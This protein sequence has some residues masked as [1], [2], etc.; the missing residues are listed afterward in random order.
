MGRDFE[1]MGT[2]RTAR[3]R[4][5]HKPFR[6]I[7]P[8]RQGNFIGR[9]GSRRQF[10][11]VQVQT[12]IHLARFRGIKHVL[13]L[14]R[15]LT[16]LRVFHRFRFFPPFHQPRGN[17]LVFLVWKRIRIAGL[18]ARPFLPS[19]RLRLGG[20]GHSGGVGRQGR[21]AGREFFRLVEG[22][23]LKGSGKRAGQRRHKLR[24]QLVRIGRGAGSANGLNRDDHFVGVG[25]PV[26]AVGLQ[27]LLHHVVPR[28]IDSRLD[29]RRRRKRPPRARSRQHFINHHAHC[30]QVGPVVRLRRI[31]GLF[32]GHVLGRPQGSAGIGELFAPRAIPRHRRDPKIH[33]LHPAV[34]VDQH[35]GG[36][37]VAVHDA[38]LVGILQGV[39][40]L[41][42]QKPR[43][44]RIQL[45]GLDE[46]V[47]RGGF[48]RL[49]PSTYSMMMQHMPSGVERKS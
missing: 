39:Q 22:Q 26:L 6:Q 29:L 34:A 3:N 47:Q 46:I 31:F 44:V 27:G 38:F 42:D 28:G 20:I 10:P 16:G 19:R 8:I 17:L 30:I 49:G 4:P 5:L 12:G 32:R 41:Q 37:D 33:H 45:A 35:V 15:R 36:F 21:F 24:R 18:L 48:A 23:F 11:P 7:F 9:F 43:A 13:R 25:I 2:P 14:R 1:Q 40:H